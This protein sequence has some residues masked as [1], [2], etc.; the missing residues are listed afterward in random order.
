MIDYALGVVIQGASQ[1]AM[2]N[3]HIA[4]AG[5]VVLLILSVIYE[6][7]PLVNGLRGGVRG[8]QADTMRIG[9]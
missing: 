9:C 8:K 5:R 6:S 2:I 3:Q 4:F 7:Y 1:M